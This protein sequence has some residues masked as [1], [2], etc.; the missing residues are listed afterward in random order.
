MLSAVTLTVAV[1]AGAPAS[2]WSHFLQRGQVTCG[3]SAAFL[4]ML[5]DLDGDGRDEVLLSAAL[6]L[7]IPRSMTLAAYGTQA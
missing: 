7:C 5:L 2:V 6:G 1:L 3:D 4:M